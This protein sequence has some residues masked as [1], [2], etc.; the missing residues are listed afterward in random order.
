M[1]SFMRDS[2]TQRWLL[3]ALVVMW[4]CAATA[5]ARENIQ[6]RTG[7]DFPKQLD[8]AVGVTWVGNPLRSAIKNLGQSQRVAVMLDRRIDPGRRITFSLAGRPLGELFATL[9]HKEN[10]GIA[11]IGPVVY[12][13][14]PETTAKLATLVELCREE[15]RQLPPA[16][17]VRLLKESSMAWD[18]P[19]QPRKLIEDEI[20]AARLRPWKIE[21]SVPHDLWPGWSMPPLDFAQRMTLLLAGFDKTF[22]VS[23]D[24]SAVRIVPI[25]DNPVIERQYTIK[26]N[27]SASLSKVREQFPRTQFE[28]SGTRLTAKGPIEDLRQ[29][30]T[31]LQTKKTP[32]PSGNGQPQKTEQR[33][34]LTIT[35]KPVGPLVSTLART[36][37]K[38]EPVFAEN[39]TAKDRQQ[40]VS[41]KVNQVNLDGLL[42][43]ALNPAGL[44]FRIEG[45][46]LHVFRSSE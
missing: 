41:L 28:L 22:E 30:A 4:L 45:E 46:K 17:L 2:H 12:F 32:R 42:R 15:I 23:K 21:E 7:K 27:S 39:V 10:L 9:A 29:I 6:W 26:R 36:Y 18:T 1:D 16:T 44:T 5:D 8:V 40:L 34:T 14:P 38:L 20:K 19:A 13:G 3:T 43:A 37:L 25:P 31:L 24:G 11:Y 35:N 33:Y